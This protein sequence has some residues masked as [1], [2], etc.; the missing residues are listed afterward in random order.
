LLRSP[1]SARAATDGR[2]PK[3]EP[4]TKRQGIEGTKPEAAARRSAR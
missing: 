2:S 4:S 3:R 1:L